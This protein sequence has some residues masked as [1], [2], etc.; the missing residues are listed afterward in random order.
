MYVPKVPRGGTES[1]SP[2]KEKGQLSLWLHGESWMRHFAS[3][4]SLPT[5]R[6]SAWAKGLGFTQASS[7]G[8]VLQT[9]MVS[10]QKDVF[11]SMHNYFAWL[12]LWDAVFYFIPGVCIFY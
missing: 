6:Q 4:K 7:V 5:I 2:E 11:T 3:P 10:I 1:E 12:F 8:T 9:C